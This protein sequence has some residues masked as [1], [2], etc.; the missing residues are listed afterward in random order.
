MA[1]PPRLPDTFETGNLIARKPRLTDA[2]AVFKAYATDP[3]V[4]RFLVWKPYTELLPLER[5]FHHCISEWESGRSFACMLC[6]PGSAEP[7]GSIHLRIEGFTA[8]FGYVLARAHWGRGLMT[9]ALSFLTRWTLEQ[10]GI[11]RSTAICDVEN[12]ASARVMEKAGMQFEGVMRRGHIAPTVGPE[13]RD[14]LVYAKVR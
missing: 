3:E 1:A 9:E 11:F 5:Y 13:P 2:A 4:T 14:C 10:P 12:K 7:I 8:R 6:L